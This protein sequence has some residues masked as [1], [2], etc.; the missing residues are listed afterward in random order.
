MATQT[1]EREARGLFSFMRV[2]SLC[3]VN[4]NRRGLSRRFRISLHSRKL[5]GYRL[6]RFTASNNV[7]GVCG[8]LQRECSPA[9]RV[10][11]I[12]FG[13]AVVAI[14]TVAITTIDLRRAREF[15]HLLFRLVI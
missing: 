7:R 6:D 15:R 1:R 12:A 5:L 2:R 8:R 14:A 10:L 9:A 13:L 3:L 11:V 4:A